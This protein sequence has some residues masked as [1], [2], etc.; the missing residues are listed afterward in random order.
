M[1]KS[2][3]TRKFEQDAL[4]FMRKNSVQ[5]PA[6]FTKAV[7]QGPRQAVMPYDKKPSGSG[8]LAGTGAPIDSTLTMGLP[9]TKTTW[10]VGY[11]DFKELG[12][13]EPGVVT[14]EVTPDFAIHDQEG[15]GRDT[16][17]DDYVAMYFLP[18]KSNHLTKITL[19]RQ[20]TGSTAPSIFFTAAINGC[21][22]FVSGSPS[23][24]TIVHAGTEDPRTAGFTKEG[25]AS[26]S[27]AF[28]FGSARTHW[29]A[30]F[31]AEL[32]RSGNP[33]KA[34]GSIH[35]GD[36]RNRAGTDTTPEALLIRDFISS[37]FGKQLEVQ[38][39]KPSGCVFGL[40]NPA[41]MEWTFY[42][43]KKVTIELVKLRKKKSFL[44]PTQRVQA[45]T[46]ET[47]TIRQYNKETNATE[48]VDKEFFTAEK[49]TLN[50]PVMLLKFYP[51][52]SVAE[53][54]NAFLE[55]DALRM[56]I[57]SQL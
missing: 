41:T 2:Q 38:D 56:A 39:V 42:L 52:E 57:R 20:L 4:N 46:T 16:T 44:R 28:G 1:A 5:P 3:L 6:D 11:A 10:K 18:W 50:I 21:S 47:K 51:G 24:P 30:L 37:D 35:S 33:G 34:Y 40:R 31:E 55:R 45:G 29:S 19:P 54:A 12:S 8:E 53:G 26:A 25:T 36:Y 49:I 27:P 9:E 15:F 7:G 43:Q 13:T 14:M 17:R 22:V 32:E 23:N 48:I